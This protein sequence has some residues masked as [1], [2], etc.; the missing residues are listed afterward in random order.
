MPLLR[1]VQHIFDR[2]ANQSSA[3]GHKYSSHSDGF[4][5]QIFPLN[6][7]LKMIRVRSQQLVHQNETTAVIVTLHVYTESDMSEN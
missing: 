2:F 7:K 1:R 5:F 6:I 4:I 3:T